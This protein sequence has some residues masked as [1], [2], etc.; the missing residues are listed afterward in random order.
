MLKIARCSLTAWFRPR[1]L[2]KG[3][4]LLFVGS[5]LRSCSPVVPCHE[6]VSEGLIAQRQQCA[7]GHLVDTSL[8]CLSA[9]AFRQPGD[10]FPSAL[11][12][13]FLRCF[14]YKPSAALY[15]S[16]PL[17]K[18]PPAPLQAG[19]G[20]EPLLAAAGGLLAAWSQPVLALPAPLS[21]RVSLLDRSS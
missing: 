9:T 16:W 18:R 17:V 21:W 7:E 19:A 15:T 10:S 2:H 6:A 1:R 3:R 20:Q 4:R 14:A 5:E 12:V 11:D 8:K 13:E